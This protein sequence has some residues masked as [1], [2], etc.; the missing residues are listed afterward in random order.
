MTM[1]SAEGR[2][3]EATAAGV[4]AVDPEI[5]RDLARVDWE[6]TP[7]GPPD[8]WSQSLRTAVSILLSSR[9]SM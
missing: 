4:F 7:L 6:S 8:G 3:H 5:G 1:G 9:F 2:P